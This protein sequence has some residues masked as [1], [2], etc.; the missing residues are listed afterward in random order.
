MTELEFFLANAKYSFS[1]IL[2]KIDSNNT[3]TFYDLEQQQNLI[4]LLS[5]SDSTTLYSDSIASNQNFINA[6]EVTPTS[7]DDV[8]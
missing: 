4:N 3:N 1:N 5:S 8:S 6:N 7:G 2:N